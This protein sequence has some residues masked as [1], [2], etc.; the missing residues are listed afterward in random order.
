MNMDTKSKISQKGQNES[1]TGVATGGNMMT[2]GN[3]G[4][5]RQT[6]FA[7]ITAGGKSQLMGSANGNTMKETKASSNMNQG[8]QDGNATAKQADLQSTGFKEVLRKGVISGVG[9]LT[10]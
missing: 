1:G 10:A 9:M 7:R 3:I 5:A 2:M 4:L 8:S 6:L